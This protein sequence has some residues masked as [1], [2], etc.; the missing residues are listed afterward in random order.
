MLLSP[1][2]ELIKNAVTV[3]TIAAFA[4]SR[5]EKHQAAWDGRWPARSAET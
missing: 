5:S 3:P 4:Y 1:A 2:V